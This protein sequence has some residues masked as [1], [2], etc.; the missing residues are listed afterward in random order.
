MVA[1]S[2]FIPA[3]PFMRPAFQRKKQAAVE[4]ITAK[5]KDRIAQHA[6]EL[7]R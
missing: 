5:L 4:A 3:H 2:F 1:G 7:R 6:S